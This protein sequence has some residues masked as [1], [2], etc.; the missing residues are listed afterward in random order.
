M[1]ERAS[2]SP[3][4]ACSGDMYPAVPITTP[5]VVCARSAVSSSDSRAGST[6]LSFAR[7]K[8]RIFTRPSFV[9]NTFSGFRSRWTMPLAWAAASPDATCCV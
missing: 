6:S 5:G 2:I 1:S 4:R 3:P 8:S 7:P 9:M